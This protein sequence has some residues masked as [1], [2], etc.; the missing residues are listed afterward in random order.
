MKNCWFCEKINSKQFRKFFKNYVP[1]FLYLTDR[2]P[3]KNCE[4]CLLFHL[5]RFFLFSRYSNFYIFSPL[6]LKFLTSKWK[7]K[8]GII[9]SWCA[10]R[11]LA[12]SI[13][14]IFYKRL[15][16]MTSILTRWQIF[17]KRNFFNIFGNLKKTSY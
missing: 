17:E 14:W 12:N 15:W 10:S 5:K 7:L 1:Y 9:M 4:K 16:V 3:F 8:D 11:K 2:K 6:S 13:F